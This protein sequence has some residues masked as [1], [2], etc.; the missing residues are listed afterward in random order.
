MVTSAAPLTAAMVEIRPE[1]SAHPTLKYDHAGSEVK[2]M[3]VAEGARGLGLGR[4]LLSELEA[5]AG[6]RGAR[7]LRLERVRPGANPGFLRAPR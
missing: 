5:W 2:G 4:R 3:W 7:T 6:Q 1:E